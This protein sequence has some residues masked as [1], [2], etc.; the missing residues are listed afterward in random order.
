MSEVKNPYL[1]ETMY[2]CLITPFD[3]RV[4]KAVVVSGAPWNPCGHMLLNTAGGWY[5]HVAEIRGRPRYMREEGYKRFLRE[6]HKHELSRTSLHIPKP[7]AA[8][9]KLEELLSKPWNWYVLPN[10]CAS[11]IEDVIEAG[12]LDLGLI[13]NCPSRET[14]K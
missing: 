7:M 6:N 1:G 14:F 3:F 10:N 11:F 2:Q 4:T 8:H 12:G 9:N 13:S 5:F